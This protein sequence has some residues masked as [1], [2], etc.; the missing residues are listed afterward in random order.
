MQL[1][2]DLILDCSVMDKEFPFKYKVIL[3]RIV[4]RIRSFEIWLSIARRKSSA[5][6]R[7]YLCR[8]SSRLSRYFLRI[9]E[10]ILHSIRARFVE[11]FYMRSEMRTMY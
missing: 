8:L 3:S 11:I 10:L 7:K 4:Q 2:K 9:S 1:E 6:D 5:E